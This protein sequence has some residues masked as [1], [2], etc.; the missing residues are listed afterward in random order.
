MEPLPKV[1]VRSADPDRKDLE[2]TLEETQAHGPGDLTEAAAD[3]DAR[4][5]EDVEAEDQ[6]DTD[7]EIERDPDLGGLEEQGGGNTENER[8]DSAVEDHEDDAHRP[9]SGDNGD[10]DRTVDT[11]TPT[12]VQQGNAP[13]EESEADDFSSD[14][15]AKKV[16]KKPRRKTKAGA[17]TARRPAKLQTQKAP[18]F[19]PKRAR[20]IK[21]PLDS[22][23]ESSTREGDSEG[24]QWDF[25]ETRPPQQPWPTF[26][27]RRLAWRDPG[28]KMRPYSLR[29]NA[30]YAL[31][32]YHKFEVPQAPTTLEAGRK[33]MWGNWFFLQLSKAIRLG[34]A[35]MSLELRKSYVSKGCVWRT[36]KQKNVWAMAGLEWPHAF[37]PQK[38][39]S[40]IEYYQRP[41]FADNMSED[42]AWRDGEKA[43]W[44]ESSPEEEDQEGEP[45]AD[46]SEDEDGDEQDRETG[47]EVT[48]SVTAPILVSDANEEQDSDASEEQ[49]M[50]TASFKPTPDKQAKIDGPIR[51]RTAP[52]NLGGRGFGDLPDFDYRGKYERARALHKGYPGPPAVDRRSDS[53]LRAL[54]YLH[55]GLLPW[56]PLGRREEFGDWYY[57]ELLNGLRAGE[58]RP[59]EWIK[60][61]YLDWGVVLPTLAQW[62]NWVGN[63]I[64]WPRDFHNDPS[65][66]PQRLAPRAEQMSGVTDGRT[67][68]FHPASGAS[69]P[70]PTATTNTGLATR[71]DQ[72]PTDNRST[73]RSPQTE[74]DLPDLS[75]I[76]QTTNTSPEEQRTATMSSPL[77][78]PACGFC[79]DPPPNAT[80][81]SESRK[82]VTLAD[83]APARIAARQKQIEGQGEGKAPADWPVYSYSHNAAGN[84]RS[85]QDWYALPYTLLDD[86]TAYAMTKLCDPITRWS[87]WPYTFGKE[88]WIRITRERIHATPPIVYAGKYEAGTRVEVDRTCFLVHRRAVVLRGNIGDNRPADNQTSSDRK[89]QANLDKKN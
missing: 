1:L 14:F 61:E 52:D 68:H 6:T 7:S 42:S 12:N 13:E 8:G 43:S 24:D 25:K 60:G 66:S 11:Q 3:H 83:T 65:L 30:V 69:A 87:F 70:R 15:A 82:W 67:F 23:N 10:D 27:W 22:D 20:N 44:E 31:M 37:R 45:T 55:D 89:K 18:R 84:H 75:Q 26:A 64:P 36:K 47:H 62:Q 86:A 33:E 21:H 73:T 63:G 41:Y 78:V 16:K 56:Q 88:G 5:D 39:Y 49:E 34:R 9:T 32:S 28:L 85:N 77:P 29:D 59:R 38:K 81:P 58:I 76:F 4:G 54:I 35:E 57:A 80:P 46:L 53:G 40:A 17:T 72:L 48:G 50:L 51:Y 19:T 74:T 2:E 79:Q 71:R